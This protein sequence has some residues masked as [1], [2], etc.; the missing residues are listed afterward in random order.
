M[1]GFFIGLV[2]TALLVYV[3]IR[4]LQKKNVVP[5]RFDQPPAKQGPPPND[6][7]T[8]LDER[9]ARGDIDVEDYRARRQA[10]L[11]GGLSRSN[12]LEPDSPGPKA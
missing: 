8:V 9:L 4:L 3:V 11:D 1:F 6:P 12:P 2:I 10:L 5:L 7:L